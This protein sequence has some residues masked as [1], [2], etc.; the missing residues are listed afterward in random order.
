MNLNRLSMM[1]A[2]CAV[3]LGALPA[4]AGYKENLIQSDSKWDVMLGITAAT[5]AE[6][7]GAEDQEFIV[8]PAAVIDFEFREKNHLFIN[9]LRDSGA[10]HMKGL[11]YEYNG[12]RIVWG[13]K[14]GWRS[15]RDEGDSEKLVGMG[16]L[17]STFTAGFYGGFNFG[18]VRLLAEYDAGLDNNNDGVLT[19]F[20]ARYNMAS[21]D[22]PMSGYIMGKVVYGDDAY[23][24]AYFGVDTP[25]AGRPTYEA[26]AGFVKFGVQGGVDYMLADHHYF[27]LD[28]NYMSL[29]ND[30][31]NS[32]I[33]EENYDFGAYLSYGYKF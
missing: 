23:Q 18:P 31:T 4:Q 5:I 6:Y 29:S 12:D 22:K 20:S 19:T 26:E 32:P 27:R 7:P 33:V 17:D 8:L 13:V 15:G 10:E 3:L 11:G 28:A 25:I 14:S 9:T 16:N 1:A 21:V 30:V 24:D 2:S